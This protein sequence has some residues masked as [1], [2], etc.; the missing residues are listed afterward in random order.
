MLS[1]WDVQEAR[2]AERG[3]DIA[4]ALRDARDLMY[5]LGDAARKL[6]ERLAAAYS[7]FDSANHMGGWDEVPEHI[8]EQFVGAM[9]YLEE[10]LM[11]DEDLAVRDAE[12]VA[13]RLDDLLRAVEV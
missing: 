4:E 8:A 3:T 1:K 9:S 5:S 12:A 10:T 7:C 6:Q 2:V 11:E 13:D